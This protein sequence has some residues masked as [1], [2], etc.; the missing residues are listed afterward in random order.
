MNPESSVAQSFVESL[1]SRSGKYA[2]RASVRAIVVH[3]T[4]SGP[5]TRWRRE[6]DQPDKAEPSPFRTAVFRIYRSIMPAAPHYVI[7]PNGECIQMC[8]ENLSAWHVGR[9]H[10]SAYDRIDW[11]T[12]LYEWWADKWQGLDSPR[13]L[14]GGRLWDHGSCNDNSIGIE[15]VPPTDDTQG[16]WSPA[17]RTT[18][19]QLIRDVAGRW[20]VKLDRFHVV[21][22]SDAHPIARTTH[23]GVPWDPGP[24]QWPDFPA[25]WAAPTLVG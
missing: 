16:T 24:A 3:T 2:V 21:S 13:D 19:E 9:E 1:G 7:G 4:G 23:Q 6:R 22:H 15:I 14:A 18:L 25:Q 11:L 8:R 12:G 5:V 10:A 17:C 20:N